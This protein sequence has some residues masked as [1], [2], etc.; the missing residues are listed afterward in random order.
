MITIFS[1][2]HKKTMLETYTE[3]L[4]GA[5]SVSCITLAFGLSEYIKKIKDATD[6]YP[7]IS[8]NIMS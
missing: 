2:R 3:L 6:I 1:P 8:P 4:D 5:K 7:I